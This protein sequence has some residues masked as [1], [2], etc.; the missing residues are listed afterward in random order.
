[1]PLQKVDISMCPNLGGN[2]PI[3]PLHFAGRLRMQAWLLRL[4]DVEE[5]FSNILLHLYRWVQMM[6]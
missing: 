2:M 6:N 3:L 1:M 4:E 5:V